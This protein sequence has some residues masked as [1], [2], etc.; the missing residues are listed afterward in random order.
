MGAFR[1]RGQTTGSSRFASREAV[2]G[3]GEPGLSGVAPWGAWGSAGVDI[4]R[5]K[6]GG[7]E[8][9]GQVATQ[10]AQVHIWGIPRW[11]PASGASTASLERELARE[12]SS[13]KRGRDLADRACQASRL[14]A[15]P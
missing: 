7:W 6:A 3:F 12:P 11:A 13:W 8:R 10:S 14:S 5:G 2:D 4:R 1:S 9:R 15:V